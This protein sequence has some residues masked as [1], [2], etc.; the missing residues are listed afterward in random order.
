MEN[1][2]W[3]IGPWAS[4]IGHGE[5]GIG[6]GYVP[7]SEIGDRINLQLEIRTS[8]VKLSLIHI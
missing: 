1:W 3:G 7:I 8:K 4:G 6:L 5:L 2:A